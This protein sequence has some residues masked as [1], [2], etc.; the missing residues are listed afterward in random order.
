MLALV[1]C[2]TPAQFKKHPE[3]YTAYH[4]GDEFE[5]RDRLVIVS[6]DYLL[7]PLVNPGIQLVKADSVATND[8]DLKFKIT[9]TVE[10]G[11]KIRVTRFKVDGGWIPCQGDKFMAN[12]V[13]K[14]VTGKSKGKTTGISLISHEDGKKRADFLT[15]KM[16]Y[17]EPDT[18][19][20]RPVH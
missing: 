4:V 20:L 14:V 1:G 16:L 12:P 17:L 13:C 5:A 3:V 18:S 11:D 7:I 10:A 19:V 8:V 9:G 6:Y 15:G 2:G